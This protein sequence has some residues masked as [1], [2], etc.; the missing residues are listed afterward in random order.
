M[1]LELPTLYA[2]AKTGKI[3]QWTVYV[4]GS[5]ITVL[6]GQMGGKQTEQ[7]TP[8][9]EGKNIG[10]AN[11][12]TP[13][14]QARSEA[15]SKWNKQYKKDYRESIEDIPESTL[16]PLAKKFQ[17]CSEA[18][19]SEYDVLCKFNGVR[20]TI[21]Y[22]NGR[23]TFQSRGGDP[24]PV[25][26]AIAD[27]LYRQV[28]K[29]WPRKVVD[30][31]LYCHGMYLEDI[32]SCVKKHNKNTPR[33]S[34]YVFDMFDPEKPDQTW[35]VRYREYQALVE[36]TEFTKPVVAE[37]VSSEKEMLA[38]HDGFVENGF[39]GVVCRKLDSK[40]VFGHRTADFQKYKVPID[41]EYKV[42]HI[43]IDKNGCAVP[44]CHIDNEVDPKRTLFKAPLIGDRE[45]QQEIAQNPEN[46]IGKYLKVVFESYTKYGLPGKPK[47]HV[48]REM[49]EDGNPTE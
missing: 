30:C 19:G 33:I 37:L 34:A 1:R 16:P 36:I 46:Y 2:K 49:D 27:E 9:T 11:E 29:S 14:E 32:T 5:T 22:N 18:L 12:T 26:Q 3:K 28:W 40:F 6:H 47:G 42:V 20:C 39:E 10:R 45:Y 7:I 41:A 17:E 31:E 13:A 35:E 8:V 15:Q 44:I 4:E 38:L 25:I 24:Y 48:F 43:D 23:P 21:F